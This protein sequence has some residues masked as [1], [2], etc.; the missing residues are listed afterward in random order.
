MSSEFEL[1]RITDKLDRLKKEQDQLK[2]SLTRLQR[3]ELI[4][5][6]KIRREFSSN[7]LTIETRQEIIAREI[8]DMQQ[9]Q[10][11]MKVLVEGDKQRVAVDEQKKRD[12]ERRER[13]KI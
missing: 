3:D 10:E 4:Q 11:Q 5:Q 6:E 2:F 1:I 9:K 8:R 13:L 7:I 12:E